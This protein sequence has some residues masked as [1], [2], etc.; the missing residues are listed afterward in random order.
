MK[1]ENIQIKKVKKGY[2]VKIVSDFETIETVVI[3]NNGLKFNR[4]F[5]MLYGD[6]I[7]PITQEI[8]KGC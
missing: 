3:E 8:L 5:S 7:K 4:V 6:Y 2:Y 1:I